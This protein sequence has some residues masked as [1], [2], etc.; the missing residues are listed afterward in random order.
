M[1]RRD[2]LKMIAA[3]TGMAMVGSAYAY[4]FAQ[5]VK[6]QDTNFK[7]DDIHFLN[8]L[9]EVIMPRTNTPGAKDAKV[10][11]SMAIMVNDCYEAEQIANF[12]N[13][14]KTIEALAQ[15]NY[16]LP[17]VKLSKDN[18]H[19][20]VS[21]VNE[22]AQQEVKR[23][24]TMGENEQDKRS[25]EYHYFIMMKQ[26]VLFCFFN[27]AEGATK[28]LRHVAIPGRYDGDMPYKKGDRAWYR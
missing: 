10:G 5:N 13:G 4:D 20:L 7:Q 24:Q 2:L 9:A 8:E 11:E 3:A 18:R 28:V 1:E 6:W 21:S 17:F 19:E 15:S 26:L 12:K 22:K 16:G 27:S 14:I 23:N 25:Y